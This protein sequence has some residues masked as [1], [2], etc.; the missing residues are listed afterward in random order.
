M[1]QEH[2]TRA[3]DAVL[4]QNPKVAAFVAATGVDRSVLLGLVHPRVRVDVDPRLDGVA[5]RGVPRADGVPA[6]Q[7]AVEWTGDQETWR[8]DVPNCR[9]DGHPAKAWDGVELVLRRCYRVSEALAEI[10]ASA[11]GLSP[12]AAIA[13]TEVSL[14]G[15]AVLRNYGPE[16]TRRGW[17]H[18][19]SASPW[20]VA[21]WSAQDRACLDGGG[22]ELRG[23]LTQIYRAVL[24][25]ERSGDKP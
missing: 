8:L 4:A 23:E 20:S 7:D 6:W 16:R 10:D 24:E 18:V 15:N 13:A 22:F 2:V 14:R 3:L 19:L 12:P 9:P 1:G 17:R 25:P 11:Y 5:V 21:G